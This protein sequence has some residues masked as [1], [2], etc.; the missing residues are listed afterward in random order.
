MVPVRIYS[1]VAMQAE[2]N[3]T[4]RTQAS[5]DKQMKRKNNNHIKSTTV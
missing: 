4:D 2:Q 3:H 5:Q 1:N